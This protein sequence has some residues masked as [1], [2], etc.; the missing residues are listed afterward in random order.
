MLK[1]IKLEI[2][3]ILFRL[4]DKDNGII[5]SSEIKIKFSE[6]ESMDDLMLITTIKKVFSELKSKIDNK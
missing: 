3:Y 6:L 4:T 2:M 1:N 5:K